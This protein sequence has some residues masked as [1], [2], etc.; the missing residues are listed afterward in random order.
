MEHFLVT[1]FITINQTIT[2]LFRNNEINIFS[3]NKKLVFFN[4]DFLK[5]IKVNTWRKLLQISL[6]LLRIFDHKQKVT[7]PRC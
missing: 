3:T 2:I 5:L 1:E 4:K 6:C 7:S